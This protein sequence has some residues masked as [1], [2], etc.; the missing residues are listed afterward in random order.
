[1]FGENEFAT[2]SSLHFEWLVCSSKFGIGL[3]VIPNNRLVSYQTSSVHSLPKSSE[4][5]EPEILDLPSRK[6]DY[7][8][9]NVGYYG[10]PATSDII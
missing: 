7:F 9:H 4:A 8:Q 5:G 3:A 2:D 10:F 1:M 6:I